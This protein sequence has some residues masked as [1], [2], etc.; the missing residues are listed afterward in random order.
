MNSHPADRW[1]Q[2]ALDRVNELY[3]EE[4]YKV[5]DGDD[6]GGNIGDDDIGDEDKKDK[7]VTGEQ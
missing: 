1:V 5:V 7:K 6:H 3:K 4:G 2:A